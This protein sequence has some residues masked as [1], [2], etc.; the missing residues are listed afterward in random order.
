MKLYTVKK[1]IKCL[2][3][4]LLII[5]IFYLSNNYKEL[6]KLAI[7]YGDSFYKI[8][9]NKN[10]E[11][12][13]KKNYS[14]WDDK[15]QNTSLKDKY[16]VVV[17]TNRGGEYSY[18]EYFK[19][20]AEKIG[21]E[22]KVYEENTYGY[23]EAILA[24]DPD[25]ILQSLYTN[26]YLG[27]KIKNHR[28]KKYLLL[29][30]SLQS[31]RDQLNMISKK[32]VFTPK[33]IFE[34]HLAS[35]NAVLT[36]AKELSIFETIFLNLKKPFNGIR[37]L[38]LVPRFDNIPAEAK[39]IF[40]GGVGWDS[41]RSSVKYKEFIKLISKNIP[42]KVYGDFL[43][44]TYLDQNVY[45]GSVP[46]GIDN[47]NAIRENGIYLLT[48][49]DT[50]I[51]SET[52]SLRIF[53]AVAANSV[54]ISDMHPF[55]IENFGDSFLY[56]DQNADA[57]TMYKQVKAHFDWILAN[58]DKAKAMAERAHQIFLDKFTLEKDLI[59]ISK[60]HEYIVQEEKKMNL[61]FSLEY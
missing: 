46:P 51:E 40:W 44:F 14:I 4:S 48:H 59:R 50:H 58:P 21:W 39:S 43:K 2:L 6:Y 16:K 29:L 24:F 60:M 42:I 8:K 11:Q 7:Q 55:A 12:A 30:L 3:I 41:Y 52:P 18:A 17:V 5:S 35:T 33:N 25:F 9:F 54:V 36:S 27:S 31:L 57:E 45:G 23:E 53:E 22:V 1:I 47:I 34:T 10:L 28:S 26:T 37:I 19:H 15:Y 20:S 61:S 56:F 32:D 38:P 49:T 13:S